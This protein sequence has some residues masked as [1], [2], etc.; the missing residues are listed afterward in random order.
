[1]YNMTPFMKI[2][3]VH[4]WKQRPSSE[5]E[6]I[7]ASFESGHLWGLALEGIILNDEIEDIFTCVFQYFLNWG[8][9]KYK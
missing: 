7:K 9:K 8:E 1:M 2:V 3:Y 4:T 6:C 5:R